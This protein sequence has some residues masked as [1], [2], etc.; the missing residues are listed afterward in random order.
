MKAIQISE[1]GSNEVLSYTELAEP[2]LNPGQ[3]LIKNQAAGVNPIDWKTCSGGGAA[4]FIG[5]LPFVPGWEFAG[6]VAKIADDVTTFSVGD[7]VFGFIRFP[8]RAGCFA[9][10]VAAPVDQISLRPAEL[11]VEAA[12][13]L[14]LAGLTAWQALFDKG[15]LKASQRVVILAGA[16]GV[17]H[18][19]I[20]LA[21]WAGAQVI[22]TASAANHD[23]LTALGADVV[24]D[25]HTQKI[26]DHAK[27]VDLV[28]DGIGGQVGI[29]AL[30]CVKP[31]GTLVTLP[32]ATKD[33]VIAAGDAIKVNVEP[34]R[35]EPNSDQLGQL[36]S[37]YAEK[38]L[39][40]NLANTYPLAQVG[41]AFD[42][43]KTGKVKGKLVL[44]I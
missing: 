38:K 19:A 24:I 42:E 33:E 31:G 7:P 10:Y 14:G 11:P 15:N 6:T 37:L 26:T 4:P 8:E 18:L 17:G 12:A 40:L 9:E 44:T 34:I 5:D 39:C 20:Q 21:K 32:S 28:I 35:V 27:D 1:F 43:S 3:V 29:E 23:F 13:G 30:A 2:E 41:N 16:G 36:A 25:Y 22:T